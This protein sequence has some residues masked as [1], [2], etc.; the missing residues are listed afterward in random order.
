[1]NLRR[2]LRDSKYS[3]H[4]NTWIDLTFGTRQQSK[5]D[6]NVFFELAS[7]VTI[8]YGIAP[9]YYSN[10]ESPY[11]V[12]RESLKST[13]DF[14]QLPTKLFSS[15]HHKTSLHFM[16]HVPAGML[17]DYNLLDERKEDNTNYLKTIKYKLPHG[18]ITIKD[19]LEP[20]LGRVGLVF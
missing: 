18:D 4:L 14:F 11:Q 15:S 17:T 12:N 1:M 6:M 5:K 8:E 3:K 20:G 19:R 13:A 7:K 2:A 10:L 9:K 16:T